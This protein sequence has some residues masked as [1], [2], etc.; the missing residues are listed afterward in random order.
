MGSLQDL[1]GFLPLS[2]ML[3]TQP[4]DYSSVDESKHDGCKDTLLWI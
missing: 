4:L 3:Y 2:K 1:L